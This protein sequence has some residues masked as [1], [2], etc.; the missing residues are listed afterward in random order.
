MMTT[1]FCH[2][3]EDSPRKTNL[4]NPKMKI[5]NPLKVKRKSNAAQDFNKA[6]EAI[7]QMG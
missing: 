6:T 5:I 7:Y 4:Y 2:I 1:A 3:A